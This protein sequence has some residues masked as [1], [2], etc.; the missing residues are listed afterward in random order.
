LR[1]F[2]GVFERE[3]A[4][5]T[6]NSSASAAACA[7][8]NADALM[9]PARFRIGDQACGKAGGPRGAAASQTPAVDAMRAGRSIGV[10]DTDT[11]SKGSQKVATRVGLCPSR[12][13]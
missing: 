7:F 12:L 10:L 11:G 3:T 13:Q 8:D 4:R 6:T 5:A 2:E 9:K 1:R